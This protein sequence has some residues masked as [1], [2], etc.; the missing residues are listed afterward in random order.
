MKHNFRNHAQDK[1]CSVR[2]PGCDGGGETTVLAHIRYAGMA[3]IGQ[4]PRDVMGIHAC[5]HCHNEID[6]PTGDLERNP[7]SWEGVVLS[8]LLRTLRSYSDEGII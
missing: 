3:G 6:G 2:L 1:P 5:Y 4:K 8:S 7:E